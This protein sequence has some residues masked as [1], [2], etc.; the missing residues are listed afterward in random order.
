[1]SEEQ[2]QQ[3]A[4]QGAE[5]EEQG[6]QAT[7]E[8]QG[9]QESQAA[10]TSE[11]TQG[12]EGHS[13]DGQWGN[14][15]LDAFLGYDPFADKSTGKE[16]GEAQSPTGE[17]R[18]AQQGQEEIPA[19]PPEGQA[20]KA[21]ASQE[22]LPQELELQMLRDQVA[23]L[24]SMVNTQQSNNG[25]QELSGADDPELNGYYQVPPTYGQLNVPGDVLESIMSGEPATVAKGLNQF[26]QG[27]AAIVHGQVNQ[28]AQ[29]REALIAKRTEARALA[30]YK[31]Q[32]EQA[33]S[34]TLHDTFYGRHKELDKPHLKPYIAM[35]MKQ[36]AAQ[37]GMQEP[38]QAFLDWGAA[39]L[40]A[41][42][43]LTAPPP[44]A[45][46]A[47]TPPQ[48][49]ATPFMSGST[50][51]RGSSATGSPSAEDD[52]YSTLFTG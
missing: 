28:Q 19:T 46:Q 23:Q 3:Q 31:Q 51:A 38:T 12:A 48:Q 50:A 10:E 36:F 44:Q 9:V 11:G 30:P 8:Q 2:V 18:Q 33:Q 52:I 47:T 7:Q 4:E 16:T 20:P 14:F 22:V 27:L 35:K 34:Q 13:D 32:Q 45:P 29:H 41:E 49:P 24:Q 40:K 5:Q 6:T 42:L 15:D 1:M 43:A 25:Q 37:V 39:K 21:E 17:T 26:A